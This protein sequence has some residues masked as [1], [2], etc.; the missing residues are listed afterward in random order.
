MLVEDVNQGEE[1]KYPRLGK[2][3]RVQTQTT[4]NYV[5][6]L[7]KNYH[8]KGDTKGVNM[9]QVETIGTYY[10]EEDEF[11][12]GCHVGASYKENPGLSNMNLTENEQTPPAMSEEEIEAHI[13]VVVLVEHFNTKK[14]INI[15]G[16]RAEIEVTKELQKI[17]DMNT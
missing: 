12:H 16:Y 1:E 2:G 15:F 9:A 8:P 4:T 3:H 14:G 13:M 10:P 6:S 5:P 17:H 11:L 7:I